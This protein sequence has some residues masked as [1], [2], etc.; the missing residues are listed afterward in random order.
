[1]STAPVDKKKVY[2][3]KQEVIE[4][5]PTEEGNRTY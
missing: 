1:M 2:Q 5:E 4:V 3:Q